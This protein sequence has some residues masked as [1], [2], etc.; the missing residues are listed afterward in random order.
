MFGG[1]EFGVGGSSSEG[2]V[3]GNFPPPSMK[4]RDGGDRVDDDES[5]DRDRDDVVEWLCWIVALSITLR[6]LVTNVLELLIL[7]LWLSGI[8][9]CLMAKL[10]LNLVNKSL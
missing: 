1:G 3:E 9:K 7:T 10:T 2:W 8:S 6:D 4:A 5:V